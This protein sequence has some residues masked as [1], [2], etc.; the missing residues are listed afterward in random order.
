MTTRFQ[1]FSRIPSAAARREVDG[2]LYA[3]IPHKLVDARIE[4][5]YKEPQMVRADDA[6]C[7]HKGGEGYI[8][9]ATVGEALL[10]SIYAPFG[11]SILSEDDALLAA[12]D[13]SHTDFPVHGRLLAG[14]GL[15]TS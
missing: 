13:H 4:V 14:S 5:D 6:R 15:S 12:L 8:W 2:H 10:K 1:C 9:F 7:F 11:V 3:R